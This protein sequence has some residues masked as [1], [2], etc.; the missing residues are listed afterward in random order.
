MEF[1]DHPRVAYTLFDGPYFENIDRYAPDPKY[2]DAV[3][4]VLPEDW[5]VQPRGFWTHC[6]APD[7]EFIAHGWKIHVSSRTENAIETLRLVAAEA[8]ALS[9]NFKFCSDRRMLR[10]S[11]NK[12]ASRSQAGK[13]IALFPRSQA[14]FEQLI[15]RVHAVTRH[16]DGPYV[17]TDRPYRDSEVVYYRYGEHRGEPRLNQYGQRVRGY[18]LDDGSWHADTREP[19]FRLPP[20]VQDP[21]SAEQEVLP[22]G[23][24]GV[25]LKGR[26]RIRQ[27]LKFNANGGV[28][29]GVD[30][31]T[32]AQVVIREERGALGALEQTSTEHGGGYSLHKE[33][34]ILQRLAGTGC[35]PGFVDLFQEWRHWFLVQEYVGAQTL[36]GDAI[37]YYLGRAGRTSAEAFESL[38]AS[39]IKLATSLQAVHAAGVVLRDLTRT[40]VLVTASGDIKF[41]DFEFS[42]EIDDAGPWIPG[43]TSGYAAP[44]QIANQVP[45]PP[46]D[47]YALGV[48]ILDMLTFSASGFDLNREGLYGRLRQNIEDLHLPR[49]LTDIVVGLTEHDP[50]K[51][52]DLQRAI[53][54]LEA[55]AAPPA[56]PLFHIGSDIPEIAPPSASL[57][58]ELARMVEQ[59]GEYLDA[60]ADFGRNDRLWPASTEVFTTNPV[61]ITH[62]AAGP[63]FFQLQVRGAVDPAVLDW[64]D[65]R[66]RARDCPPGLYSGLAGVALLMSAA[67]RP[68]RA[69]ALIRESNVPEMVYEAPGLYYG[70][71]GWGFANLHLWRDSGKARYLEQACEVADWLLRTGTESDAGLH[72]SM[73]GIV[74]LGLGEGQAG[75]A[76]FLTYLAA[77]TDEPR[78]LQAAVRALDFD[79]AHGDEYG[80]LLLWQ[81]TVDARPGDPRS[82]HTWYG[83]SG[84]G[85]ACLR[86]HAATGESRFLEAAQRCALS[87]ASRFTNKIWQFEGASGFGEFLLDIAQFTGDERYSRI[88]YYQSEILLPHRIAMPKGVAFAGSD[89][90][91]ICCEYS[92]GSSGI[93][94]F[95]D[96]LL[97][98]KQRLLMLDAL[99][100]P[101]ARGLEE[102][103]A[104]AAALA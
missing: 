101:K 22:P 44:E 38:R 34:R 88:A 7:A 46:D 41:I 32:G 28:Y 85:S 1:V 20:G 91:R 3:R 5:K 39:A 78:Y 100:A 51:R 61:N 56:R 6:Y 16:L 77:A 96:R 93:G 72:W 70:A 97:H 48:L 13:F 66:A 2:R 60:S 102:E 45:S 89:H 58:A 94:L 33:A 67:G 64:I 75:I 92:E 11:L 25:L 80:G 30:E 71:A 82:P 43:G 55:I 81:P 86:C 74:S 69:E 68:D 103:G 62:G 52:W 4:A 63:A 98:G 99:L 87:V 90:F 50:A 79:L 53:T 54:A 14:E 37:G 65:A 49:E 47:H 35:A 59:I 104:R 23:D 31:T 10:L 73:Q 26:Y 83:S 12:N 24:D 17:L 84:I 95:V 40:N 15:E 21:F 8:A 57:K 42:H 76:L 19:R 9:V 18:R 27:A 29:R 36:W